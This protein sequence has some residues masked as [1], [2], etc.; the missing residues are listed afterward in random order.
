MS[1]DSLIKLNCHYSEQV[2]KDQNAILQYTNGVV[3]LVEVVELV[4]KLIEKRI[5]IGKLWFKLPYEDVE[6]MKS[7]WEDV[8]HNKQRMQASESWYKELDIYIE[9]GWD[10]PDV[11]EES[12]KEADEENTDK[13]IVIF[14]NQVNNEEAEKDA[15]EDEEGDV[16][17]DGDGEESDGGS[18]GSDAGFSDSSKSDDVV[19]KEDLDIYENLNYDEQILDE[20][21]VY[22]ETDDSSG[23]EEEQADMLVKKNLGDG[24]FSLRQLFS[25]G[26]EFKQNV[27]R[28]ILKTR[29]NVRI[30]LENR[31]LK[32]MKMSINVFRWK[33]YNLIISPPKSQVA[34][35][36]VLHKL[37]AETSDQFARLRD[38]AKHRACASYIYA[39]VTKNHKSDSLKPLF[40]RVAS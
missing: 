14:L 2:K 9:K 1:N 24:V 23:D 37:Q 32:N 18:N 35:R 40:W 22:L 30:Q 33:R 15:E 19:I 7:L 36:M 21:E 17:Y 12:G 29:R 26:N 11:E 13:I 6:D 31:S 16:S 8:E 27:I 3:D 10:V 5:V 34:R 25:S 4:S 20:D 39:N 28:Y 38:Y